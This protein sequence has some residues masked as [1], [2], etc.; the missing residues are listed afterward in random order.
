[1][2]CHSLAIFKFQQYSQD[3][4]IIDTL[5]EKKNDLFYKNKKFK[6]VKKMNKKIQSIFQVNINVLWMIEE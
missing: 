6:A 1:M 2:N 3:F 4:K 5:S